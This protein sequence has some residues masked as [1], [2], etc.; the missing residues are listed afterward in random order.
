M[1]QTKAQLLDG[2]SA[3]IQFTAGSASAPAVSFT[4]D[5]NTGIYSPGADQV[6]ISTGGSGRLFV[7]ASGNIGIGI[8]SPAYPLDVRPTGLGLA[9]I[10]SQDSQ[11]GLYISSGN[12][13][14]PFINFLTSTSTLRAAIFAGASSDDLIF[15]TGASGTERVRIDSS[16]RLLVGASSGTAKLEAVTSTNG[17]GIRLGYANT[18]T[19][20]AGPAV[21][22][23]QYNNASTLITTSSIKGVLTGGGVGTETGDLV[24]NTAIGGAA[25]VERMRIG[26]DSTVSIQNTLYLRYLGTQVSFFAYDPQGGSPTDGVAVVVN[27]GNDG[28]GS[29]GVGV[30]LGRSATS[31][32]TYSDERGKANLIPIED[33]L[34]KVGTL[35]AVTG[36]YVEDSEQT[37]RSFLIA[38]DVQAVLPEAVDVGNPDK[39][40]LRYTEVIPLL[41]AALKESK[42]R[43][44]ALEAAVAALQQS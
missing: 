16:G 32:S 41:V 22:F 7:D 25:P 30:A 19:G 17:D 12:N 29:N 37:S 42:E 28:S 33:G 18:P 6:A 43:I 13:T 15:A 24:F 27:R 35:R 1:S 9:R 2:K 11:A 4:G 10:G 8:A 20:S 44:E 3:T 38:Q 21:A 23:A 34:F 36:H 31:W 26:G 39:L 40:G 14:S 5:T